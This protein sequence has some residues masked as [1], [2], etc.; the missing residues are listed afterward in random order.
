MDVLARREEGS[1]VVVGTF[2]YGQTCG[3]DVVGL[4]W[5]FGC[6]TMSLESEQERVERR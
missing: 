4:E 2:V 1:H 6:W 3:V 5:C